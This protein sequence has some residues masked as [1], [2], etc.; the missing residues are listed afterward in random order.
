M[1]NMTPEEEFDAF[2]FGAGK[3]SS[4]GQ[5]DDTG[6]GSSGGKGDDA[7]KGSSKGKGYGAAKG[8]SKGKGSG[9]RK[10]SSE[11]KGKPWDAYRADWQPPRQNPWPKDTP[12]PGHLNHAWTNP[13]WD[14]R[15]RNSAMNRQAKRKWE[16]AG[17][18]EHREAAEATLEEEAVAQEAAAQE[19]AKQEEEAAEWHEAQWMAHNDSC[20]HYLREQNRAVDAVVEGLS[21]WSRTAASPSQGDIQLST[22]AEEVGLINSLITKPFCF[23]LPA[24]LQAIFP[25][26]WSFHLLCCFSVFLFMRFLFSPLFYV[27]L[28]VFSFLLLLCF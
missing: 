15:G 9:A 2:V 10:R 22:S 21:Q 6:K 24:G 4:E 8:S 5:G 3:G 16:R 19:V 7:G 12:R 26:A 23:T 20:G 14:N 11:G 28:K 1:A 13:H 18:E 17:L 25:I 27:C